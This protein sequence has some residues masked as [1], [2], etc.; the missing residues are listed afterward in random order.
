ME[1]KIVADSSANL[2]SLPEVPFS[3]VP[4]K[5]ITAQAEY[6]DDARLDV[7]AM[8]NEIK[9]TKGKSGTSCPNVHDWLQ[10]F[11]D[12]REIFAIT[13]TSN[14][15]GS[16][17]AARQAKEQ[18]EEEHP[19]S[20]VCVLDSLSTGPEMRLIVER[21][22]ELIL[23]GKPFQKIKEAI[24]AYQSHTHLLFSLQ[25]LTNLARN[26]RVSP[27]VAKVAG[28]LGI[29]LVGAASQ[30]GT[31]QPLHKCRGE[32]KTLETILSEMKNRCFNGGRVRIAH[33]FN[34]EAAR[35]LKDLILS[36]FPS[37]DVQIEPCGA[38]CSFYAERGGLLV[39]FADAAAQ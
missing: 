22:K 19:G 29:R 14:L 3:S 34:L 17:A 15:S 25:S 35:Q 4:L 16:C 28:V 30:E 21:L 37:S 12:A 10:A 23:E 26:G 9:E 32:K 31:L 33:C 18:Y 27:I 7:E 1:Q 8:V 6:V 5:I 24:R 39:G 20:Q 2:F 36:S 11:G 13:I 38:L